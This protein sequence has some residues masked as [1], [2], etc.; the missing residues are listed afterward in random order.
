MSGLVSM[1]HRRSSVHGT[2][3]RRCGHR[4]L[5]GTST[6]RDRS[7]IEDDPEGHHASIQ[8]VR[9]MRWFEVLQTK[10]HIANGSVRHYQVT[11]RVGFTIA[12]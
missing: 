8:T 6:N 4:Q 9:E 10:G 5:C 7:V 11:L 1:F 2:N 3:G 12:D